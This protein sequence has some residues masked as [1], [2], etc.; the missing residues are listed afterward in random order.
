MLALRPAGRVFEDL[1]SARRLTV[2]HANKNA[3]EQSNGVDLVY[4]V[5]E[6]RSFVLLQYKRV[7]REGRNLLLRLDTQL[8]KESARMRTIETRFGGGTQPATDLLGYRLACAVCFF[9]L[10]ETEQPAVVPV[11]HQQPVRRAGF[12]RMDRIDDRPVRVP[13]RGPYWTA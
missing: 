5:H 7:R 2:L 12:G 4:F 8:D 10:C 9:K 6:Y 11:L 1:A 3:I 13:G